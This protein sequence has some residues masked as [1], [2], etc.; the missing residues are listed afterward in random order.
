MSDKLALSDEDLCLKHHSMFLTRIY[1][2][3]HFLLWRGSHASSSNAIGQLITKGILPQ[4]HPLH[5]QKHVFIPTHP[6]NV[7]CKIPSPVTLHW[8]LADSPSVV[9]VLLIGEMMVGGD[10]GAPVSGETTSETEMKNN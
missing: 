4:L 9:E 3:I 8:N 7:M 10:R 6:N 5:P 1:N 2:T